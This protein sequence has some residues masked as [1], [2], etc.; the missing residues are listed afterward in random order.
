MGVFS[1]I[2]R[3]SGVAI[4]TERGRVHGQGVVTDAFTTSMSAGQVLGPLAFGAAVDLLSIHSVFYM[5]GIVGFA[6][7]VGAYWFLRGD[8][9]A[10]A[11]ASVGTE[12]D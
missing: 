5:G 10:G 1:A 6:G 3:A 12:G 9:G 2:S 11:V 8:A 4:R 7:T